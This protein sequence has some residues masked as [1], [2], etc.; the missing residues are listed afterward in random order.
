[1][2][3]MRIPVI[4]A[5]VFLACS[6]SSVAVAEDY[7]KS[8]LTDYSQLQAKPVADGTDL[9]YL[10]PGVVRKLA[11][12]TGVMVDQPEV[13][14]SAN[15]DYKGAK[16]ADL[17][18]VAQS[19]R[20]TLDELLTAAGYPVVDTPGPGVISVRTAVTDVSIK[21]KKLGL[22][23]Y[24][25]E[26]LFIKAGSISLKGVMARYDIMAMTIQAELLDS[27]SKEVLARVVA[28]RRGESDGKPV[29]IDF[30]RVSATVKDFRSRLRCLPD[31]TDA[32][33]AQQTPAAPQFDCLDPATLQAGAAIKTK[34]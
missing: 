21:R 7:D 15:S 10:S 5:S 13:S 2:S 23:G 6:L 16:P 25:P 14:I 4:S 1:M 9:T 17:M 33:P 11:R 34:P 29:R 12:Y 8:F 24:L 18:A 28:L 19:L 22:L 20:K 26:E 30:D 31:N 32:P 3:R 27:D